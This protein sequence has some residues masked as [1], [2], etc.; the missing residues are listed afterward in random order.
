MKDNEAE[1][2]HYANIVELL[3]TRQGHDVTTR[4]SKRGIFSIIINAKDEASKCA[5]QFFDMKCAPPDFCQKG[6]GKARL[7]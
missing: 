2:Q 5:H 6:R 7:Q 4:M 3:K 1:L